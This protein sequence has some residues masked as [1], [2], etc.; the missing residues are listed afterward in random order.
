[1]AAIT[2]L[3]TA[4]TCYSPAATAALARWSID[5][6]EQI[7]WVSGDLTCPEMVGK[8]L[9]AFV[10]TWPERERTLRAHARALSGEPVSHDLTL[11][12][13]AF[14][15]HLSP[16][17]AEQQIEGVLGAAYRSGEGQIPPV[18]EN[19]RALFRVTR[20]LPRSTVGRDDTLVVSPDAQHADARSY[21]IRQVDPCEIAAYL[22][23]P[24]ACSLIHANHGASAAVIRGLLLRRLGPRQAI[25]LMG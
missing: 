8:S 19:L 14:R 20:P 22:R 23:D 24:A 25:R 17:Y 11:D 15:V 21:L 2:A 4:L 1:M 13:Q 10:A 9:V 5:R 6:S 12:G 3:S 16:L 7:T 18:T